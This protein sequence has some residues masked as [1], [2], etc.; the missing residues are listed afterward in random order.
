MTRKR[1]TASELA[2]AAG[3]GLGVGLAVM[4]VAKLWLERTPVLPPAPAPR[5]KED[6]DEGASAGAVNR[7]VTPQRAAP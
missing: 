2:V 7:T 1:L 5:P 6:A 3:V 4:Y